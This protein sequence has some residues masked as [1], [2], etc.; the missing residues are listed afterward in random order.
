V[1]EINS[2]DIALPPAD[3]ELIEA[4]HLAH[5][6]LQ[7]AEYLDVDV[8]ARMQKVTKNMTRE[9]ILNQLGTWYLHLK[10]KAEGKKAELE[11]ILKEM[12]KEIKYFENKL[13]F[14]K[15][16]ISSTLPPGPDS[17][18]VNERVSLFYQKS[19][20]VKVIDAESVPVEFCKIVTTLKL[21]EIKAALLMGEDI[22]GCEISEKY[23]LRV[24]MG[25]DR[26]IANA[27]IRKRKRK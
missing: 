15:W 8:F 14:V 4:L 13:D 12:Q 11:P 26:A 27:K 6:Q 19:E 1:N 18:F 25:G 22:S 10:A 23:S 20:S 5:E 3:D 24:K 2:L 17:E 16:A 7:D 9:E 21:T